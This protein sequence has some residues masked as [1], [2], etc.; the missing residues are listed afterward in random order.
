[1][2]SNRL[3]RLTK[4]EADENGN[5]PTTLQLLHVGSWNTPW[6]G[7]FEITK[8]DIDEFVENNRNG[9]GLPAEANSRIQINYNHKSYEK[10]AGWVGN[11]RAEYVDSVY[12]LVGD[13]EYTP[14]AKKA[15][16]DGEYAYVSPEFNPRALP[17]ED[18]EEEWRM[19][20]NVIT[21]VALC[22]NPL[23]KK[24]KKVSASERPDSNKPSKGE[25]MSLK[26]EEVRIL[27]ASAITADHRTFLEEHKS[28]LSAD[29]LAKFDIKADEKP[30]PVNVEGD[31]KPVT[32]DASEL[33]S[34]KA[35]A[36]QGV[37]AA[38]ELAQ[39]KASSF[40]AARI[41]AGQVKSDQKDSLTKIL[42]ASSAEA[43]T[44]LE[45]FLS[46]LPVN[47]SIGTE[48]GDGG[49]TVASSA[50]DE[51]HTKVVEKIEADSEGGKPRASYS[52]VRAS[53][54]AADA[55]LK[56]RINDEEDK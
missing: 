13:P 40:A 49:K 37:E 12:S 53:V 54:L 56:Q 3:I 48:L 47:G 38:Q 28:E 26:L 23:F 8:A 18:P 46:G 7:D 34:L 10:G 52:S 2:A 45:S 32:I 14:A 20:A 4:I 33:A 21:G 51:L 24:L 15:I 29:E 27:E 43:R 17:W 1:M 41:E 16:A 44:E 25:P 39:T 6:H 22:N 50:H 30:A 31:A 35:A 19:V 5:L 11:I 55:D 36:Q 9:V 42:L